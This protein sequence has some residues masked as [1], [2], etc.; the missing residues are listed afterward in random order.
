MYIYTF[1]CPLPLHFLAKLLQRLAPHVKLRCGASSPTTSFCVLSSVTASPLPLPWSCSLSIS[2]GAA[3]PL[4]PGPP[5]TFQLSVLLESCC[6]FHSGA[7]AGGVL[8]SFLSPWQGPAFP[9]NEHMSM[10]TAHTAGTS[11]AL[12][13]VAH[14]AWLSWSFIWGQLGLHMGNTA[15][16]TLTQ[17]GRAHV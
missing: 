8:H 13:H 5:Q 6:K 12:G 7:A 11:M 1:V 15:L 9:W 4:S 14:G 17:I 16:L 3:P 2:L 10:G